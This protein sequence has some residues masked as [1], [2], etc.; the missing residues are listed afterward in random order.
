MSAALAFCATA[1]ATVLAQRLLQRGTTR[2]K[3][4]EIA[5]AFAMFLFALASAALGG[6]AVAVSAAYLIS[7]KPPMPGP[8]MLCTA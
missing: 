1:I 5:W 8:V 6:T 2:K 3:A 7:R 4:H